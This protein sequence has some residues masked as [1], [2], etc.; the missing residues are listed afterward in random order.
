MHDRS[1][2]PLR[3]AAGLLAACAIGL[4]AAPAA[5]ASSYQFTAK[6]YTESLGRAPDGAGWNN[7]LSYFTTHGCNQASLAALANSFYVSAEY[8]GL[9]YAHSEQVLTAYRGVLSREP[10]ADEIASGTQALDSGEPLGTF[11]NALT[12]SGEFAGMVSTICQ[13]G[14]YAWGSN[15]AVG[16]PLAG[17]VESVSA[18]RAR[19]SAAGTTAAK[20]PQHKRIVVALAPHAIYEVSDGP[21]V[22]PTYV[23][24]ATQDSGGNQPLHTHYASMARIVRTAMF[25]A[26]NGD[27]GTTALVML[28]GGA[29]LRSV[30]V[31]GQRSFLAGH[32]FNRGSTNVFALS[33]NGTSIA[34]VRSDT[35]AGFSNLH[36]FGSYEDPGQVACTSETIS[37]TLITAYSANHYNSGEDHTDGITFSCDHAVISGNQIVDVSDVGIVAFPAATSV[38]R[39]QN[40]LVHD[41]IVVSAGL[42]AYAAYGIDQRAAQNA[43]FAG[44]SFDNNQFFAAPDSHF[45][46]GLALG[47]FAWGPLKNQTIAGET[48]GI[49]ASMTNNTTAG[50]STP[51]QWGIVVDGMV[52]ATVQGNAILRIPTSH[53]YNQHNYLGEPACPAGGNIFAHETGVSPTHGSGNLQ[54]P[55]IDHSLDTCIVP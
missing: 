21:I 13:P 11:I 38:P 6:L 19:L 52:N 44:L 33:G 14:G 5:Q 18:L 55:V 3:R 40:S 28:R 34:Q 8:S 43:S 37:G 9:G 39:V 2:A 29:S 26:G 20:D 49:G 47:S 17:A 35:S 36:T 41:N 32:P 54:Q 16:L 1:N 50:V 25:N 24:L 27:E 46:I 31:S 10:R 30:W 42:P 7:Y 22:V 4:C 53:P 45:D 12:S 23:T 51:L 15:K 48:T